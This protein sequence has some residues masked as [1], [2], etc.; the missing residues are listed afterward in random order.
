[1][2]DVAF[3][4]QLKPEPSEFG[5]FSAPDMKKVKAEVAKTPLALANRAAA[6]TAVE[7]QLM[8]NVVKDDAEDMRTKLSEVQS[9]IGSVEAKLYK[10][11]DKYNKT[12]ADFTR[13][14]R[15]RRELADLKAIKDKYNAA[16][17]SA[18]PLSRA[19]S[20]PSGLHGSPVKSE[21]RA[22]SSNVLLPVPPPF[23]NPAY[24]GG[25]AAFQ[26]VVH[27]NPAVNVFSRPPQPQL[28]PRVASGSNVKLEAPPVKMEID[29]A[30]IDAN[31]DFQRLTAGVPGFKSYDPN[32]RRFDAD[33]DFFGR[34][35]DTFA[36]PVAK[37]D[38]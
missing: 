9:Q 37:A 16:L 28:Q 38:E 12:K 23:Y 32:D 35:K 7:R 8:S 11:E 15:L 33:G 30:P 20:G 4:I 10:A 14:N 34:G 29:P 6:P 25:Q 2:S 5:A 13:I 27:H 21:P 31:L 1:M 18:K 22:T 3:G 19:G 26:P 24:N 36:G 17:P